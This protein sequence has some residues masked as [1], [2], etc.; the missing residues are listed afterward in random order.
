M[1]NIHFEM[2]KQA[3]KFVEEVCINTWGMNNAQVKA[4][5]L[6]IVKQ[7]V[8]MA[9]LNPD[10]LA[11]AVAYAP[12]AGIAAEELQTLLEGGETK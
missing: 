2:T 3:K 1:K 11:T 10:Y 4:Y 12:C 7:N 6:M 8:L 5:C 9:Q